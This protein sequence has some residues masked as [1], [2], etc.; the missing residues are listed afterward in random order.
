MVQQR[1]EP[2]ILVPSCYL[3]HTAQRTGR[4]GSGT[5][6]GMRFA[7]RVPLGSPPFLPHL[8]DRFHGLVR[9]VRRYYGAIRLPTLVHFG[10]TTSVFPKRPAP[11][12]A[13]KGEHGISRFSHLEVPYVP[14]FP[15]P[16]GVHWRLA[17]APPAV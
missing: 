16:R 1:G 10:L 9:R 8:R 13:G 6:S 3:T 7:V 5:V 15:R 2:R 14:W 12:I 11:V 17:I 4:I